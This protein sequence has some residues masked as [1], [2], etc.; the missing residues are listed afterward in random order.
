[1]LSKNKEKPL[2]SIICLTYNH[3]DYIRK[4]LEGFVSQK[5]TF[6][7]EIIVHD[8]ASTD[9]TQEIL[10][11]YESK[12]PTLFNNI[13]QTQNQFK[14]K[15]INIWIDFVFPIIV[16]KYVAFC[17]GDDYWVDN[18]KLQIQFDF[19][20]NNL[21]Y[22][23]CYHEVKILKNNY[24]LSEDFIEKTTKKITNIYD[25]AVWGNY[26]HTCSVFLRNNFSSVNNYPAEYLCD[27][28]L[29]MHAV[30][31]GKIKKISSI[32]SVYRYGD[33]IWASSTSIMKYKF[34]V[35]NIHNILKT[36]DD[37]TIREIMKM[38]LNSEALYQLPNYISQ[39]ENKENR[40][41]SFI[42]NEKIPFSILVDVLRV[43]IF[44]YF[45]I[46]LLLILGKINKI[47]N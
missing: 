38:R 1:M 13:Y 29:Y 25:L 2:V 3:E 18:N 45:K 6:L 30:N 31:S 27:Y 20:E 42:L 44:R 15:K 39:I 33:G 32:M 16:G 37:D 40:K 5:T 19:L 22:N 11:E 47:F 24:E 4:C 10:R 36:T 35:D 23:L 34:L 41:I 9:N 8:D 14:N 28:F 17:E 21:D 46:I 43:K 12:Y 7:F 26:I